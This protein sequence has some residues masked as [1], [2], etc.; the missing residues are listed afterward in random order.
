MALL[1]ALDLPC[2]HPDALR[3][4]SLFARATAEALLIVHVSGKPRALGHLADLY[5][6][7][8]PLRASRASVRIRD[9]EGD[10]ADAICRWTRDLLRREPGTVVAVS[11]RPLP[12]DVCYPTGGG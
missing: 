4:A 9:V 1:V 3:V 8:A 5:A 6:L 7:A 10:P 2:A 12:R 11:R